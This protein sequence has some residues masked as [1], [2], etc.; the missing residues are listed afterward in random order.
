MISFHGTTGKNENSLLSCVIVN[1]INTLRLG[2]H[3]VWNVIS[4]GIAAS[5]NDGARRLQP[6]FEMSN[7]AGFITENIYNRIT[8]TLIMV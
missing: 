4:A 3:H 2:V 5:L 7:V 6:I 1:D 8:N